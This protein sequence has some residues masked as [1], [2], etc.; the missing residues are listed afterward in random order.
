MV[1]L[2]LF[3]AGGVIVRQQYGIGVV[4]RNKSGEM[5]K[6]IS[7]KVESRGNQYN[8]PDLEPNQ[9][10]RVFV[11]PV[12]KSN[13]NVQFT[14]ATGKPHVEVVAGYVAPGCCGNVEATIL[15]GGKAKMTEDISLFFCRRS[16]LDFV[17]STAAMPWSITRNGRTE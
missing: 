1:G 16:W 17:S 5:L 14:D 11:Q 8:L 12:G 3:Y 7:V 4:I 10:G 6:Q 13:I 15:P 9:H 2:L